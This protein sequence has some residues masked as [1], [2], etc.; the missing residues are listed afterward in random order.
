C[1]GA[2]YAAGLATGV[3]NGLGELK[4]HWRKDAEWQPSMA[5]EVREGEDRNWRRAVARSFGWVGEGEGC[6]RPAR[7]RPGRDPLTRVLPPRRRGGGP[8]TSVG[9]CGARFRW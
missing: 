3:W 4:A 1:L 9:W 7:A 6:T 5:D 2:A 8:A